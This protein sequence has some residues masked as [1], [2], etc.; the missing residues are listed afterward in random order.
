MTGVLDCP[1][2]VLLEV[3]KDDA[4]T[5]GIAFSPLEVV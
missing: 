1:L 2:L 3:D 4:K 5:L